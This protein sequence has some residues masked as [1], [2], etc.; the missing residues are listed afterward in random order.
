MPRA[1]TYHKTAKAKVRWHVRP[2]PEGFLV[3]NR[4]TGIPLCGYW[5][6]YEIAEKN[7]R[8]YFGTEP[9]TPEVEESEPP[10]DAQ[11][12]QARNGG[13]AV[14]VA[15]GLDLPAPVLGRER[16]PEAVDVPRGEEGVAG[17]GAPVPERPAKPTMSPAE[18]VQAVVDVFRGRKI[19]R[20]RQR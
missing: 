16:N 10:A 15:P 14:A 3:V 12:A 11:A 7:G 1:G 9:S 17:S 18:A 20:Q 4:T 5:S 6:S 8:S 19:S 2:T 13:D